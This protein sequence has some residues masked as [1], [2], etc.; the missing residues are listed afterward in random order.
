MLL[1]CYSS[2]FAELLKR[3]DDTGGIEEKIAY[4]RSTQS[5]REIEKLSACNTEVRL[6]VDNS[7]ELR[8]IAG[9]EMISACTLRWHCLLLE[10]WKGRQLRA[11][12]ISISRRIGAVSWRIGCSVNGNSTHHDFDPSK[13]LLGLEAGS[14][15]R[16]VTL[17]DGKERSWF[18]PNGQYIRELPCPSCRGRGYTLC[19]ECGIDRSRPD[20]FQCNGKGI[21]TCWQCL[22]ECVIWEESYDE[23]PWEKARSS[24]LFKVKEDDD[25]DNLEVKVD[26]TRKSKRI[27]RTPTPEVSMKISR[28]LR[29]LNAKTGL[30]SKRMK[31]I[32]QDPVLHAQR[33]A[34]IKKTK[35]T[36][37]ARKRASEISKAYFSDPGNRLK[38]SLAMKGV[39]FYCS[40]CGE[41]GHRRHYCQALRETSTKMSF[42]C[43]SCGERGHNRRT[44][45]RSTTT[46]MTRSRRRWP[47]RCKLCGRSG[48]HRSTCSQLLRMN[49]G[50]CLP[51]PDRSEGLA[52]Q[53][54][55]LCSCDPHYYEFE[56]LNFNI[57]GAYFYTNVRCYRLDL[58]S[59]VDNFNLCAES[60]F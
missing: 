56:S 2:Y 14:R 22:G 7:R 37:D 27:Y 4:V 25:V 5:C 23:R 45:E 42:R 54:E 10:R 34:A 57:H 26:V 55:R 48:H 38:R 15:S 36:P 35:G 29:S 60:T 50:F 21:K 1:W 28:S 39:K 9:D 58:L 30:F 17:S 20:C 43:S 32:H 18:G 47:R 8:F 59:A 49:E 51:F 3:N 41:E 44:C 12:V 16:T 40:H 19:P 24:S 31:I 46:E 13:E 33:V 52:I 11:S 53:S 6:G